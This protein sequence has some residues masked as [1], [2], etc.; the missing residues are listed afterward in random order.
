MT[1]NHYIFIKIIARQQ[2]FDAYH[3][4]GLCYAINRDCLINKK[5]IMGRKCLPLF[6]KREISNIDTLNDLEL[7]EYYFKKK[8]Y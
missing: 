7:A 6:V 2:L 4:N 8:N 1:K 5:S 3:K